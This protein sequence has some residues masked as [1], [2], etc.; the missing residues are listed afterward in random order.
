MSAHDISRH[1]FQPKKHYSG[2]RMQQ[3]RVSL[4]S[5]FNE[6]RM[7]DDEGQ[8]LLARDVIGPHG[9]SDGGFKITE[10]PPGPPT[11]YNFSIGAG[12]YYLGGLRH[13][14][15][16]QTFRAQSD[17]QQSTRAGADPPV[18][19]LPTV[20]GTR[21]DLVYL[22][23]W[24]QGVT[25]VE[26]TEFRE[27]AIAAQD[28]GYRIRLM[29]RAYV[30]TGGPADCVDAFTALVDSLKSGGH[31]FDTVNNQLLSGARLTVQYD[32]EAAEAPD[33]CKPTALQ[34]FSG[35]E[36]ET[37]RVQL[38]GGK[39]FLWSLDNAAP[40]YRVTVG[41]V[42]PVV[43]IT[44]QSTT[45]PRDA[46]HQPRV[47]QILEILPW[48]A[49]L[50]NGEHVADHPIAPHVGGSVLARVR[51]PY[52]PD[53]A[54]LTV[55]LTATSATVLQQMLDWLG[56]QP[57]PY[58]FARVWNPGD[59]PGDDTLDFLNDTTIGVPFQPNVRVALSGTGYFVSF[60]QDGV[61]GDH[62]ILTTRPATTR[63]IV[64][65][66][67]LKS[68]AP[69]GPRRF[70]SPLAIIRWTLSGGGGP[71]VLSHA[72]HD[73]R[74]K[75]RPLTRLRG[76]CTVTVGDDLNSFGDFTSI[77]DAIA[78]IPPLESG[79]ICILPGTYA[80]RVVI[81][82]RSKLVIEG[83]GPRTRIR[84]PESNSTSAGLV[85]ILGGTDVTLRSL[86]I[87]ADGQMGVMG[88]GTNNTTLDR[89][90]VTT[91]RDP[92]L[93]KP[94][95]STIWVPTE[96]SP[97][98]LS[99]VAF[100][101]SSSLSILDC[102]LTMGGDTSLAANVVV[103]NSSGL[104]ISR[105]KVSTPPVFG[106]TSL[107]FGGVYLSR[108]DGAELTDNHITRGNGHGITFG[109]YLDGAL[110]DLEWWA[111]GVV[112][113]DSNDCPSVGPDLPDEVPPQD[114]DDEPIV[115]RP[116]INTNIIIRRNRISGMGASGISVLGFWPDTADPFP[117]I[118]TN[119]LEIADN[120]IETNCQTPPQQGMMPEFREVAAFGGI[121]LGQADHLR[122]HDNLIQDNGV[123]FINPVCGIFVLHGENIAIENNLIRNHGP[124]QGN[125]T[126]L[127]GMRAGI[128]LQQVGRRVALDGEEELEI[129]SDSLRPSA[130][131]RG[132]VVSQPAG[133]ALQVYGIGAML[134]EGNTLIS[135]GLP[136][137]LP[138]K[139]A[140][141]VDIRNVGQSPELQLIGYI[142]ASVAFLPAPA[143]PSSSIPDPALVDGRVLFT[144]NQVRF[145]PAPNTS[146]NIFCANAIQSYGD[147]AVL[148]NQFFVLYPLGGGSMFC[149]TIVTAWSTR[150]NNNR[151]EDP[152]TLLSG[153]PV[154]DFDTDRSA[155][156]LGYMNFTAHN[157]AT[158]CIHANFAGESA[159]W[160]TIVTTCITDNHIASPCADD[161][162]MDG[163]LEAP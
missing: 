54:S 66:D 65:W 139:T 86:H 140:H 5:D 32:P 64:P 93:A 146:F 148:D 67:L 158:R 114:D 31:E 7:L 19:A 104:R 106:G 119:H 141:C 137:G 135:E 29:H 128:A 6:A 107:A 63:D 39:R 160:I 41:I 89:L 103:C 116:S 99:T 92:D 120:I 23:G 77:N 144:D 22:V 9:T 50:P 157:Q 101:T 8:R 2:L 150:T 70:Y 44:F 112:T 30:R 16:S 94:T 129:G 159:A 88:I 162:G 12:S 85:T 45:L 43:T 10:P 62:W 40:L 154:Y 109:V 51:T 34:G 136:E 11:G 79:K 75:F 57:N 15:S 127:S 27:Q 102:E 71:P 60:N 78:A 90:H 98:P 73:C 3:G 1:L 87:E 83:C 42:G 4:D 108:I 33:L 56:D 52:D 143:L 61:V 121:A 115:L 80:E 38:I 24:E 123:T 68:A 133:R 155:T 122:I 28:T 18:P 152:A 82:N 105:C 163:L 95:A 47:G 125:L 35:A 142:P 74:P 111:G 151:W 149:D 69:H 156:T 53:G 26:D 84:T 161:D 113:D 59:N 48:G 49:N 76:C 20:A 153:A 14:I 147:I 126:P 138:D 58:L 117:M 118:E 100:T 131:V 13:E 17:W 124:R 96:S 36:N 81:T 130:L 25:S 91:R 97:Y 37:I 145:T 134:I 72:Y 110:N 21:H 132:N 55:V 46:A